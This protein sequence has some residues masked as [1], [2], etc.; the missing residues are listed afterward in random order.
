MLASSRGQQADS[1]DPK[2]QQV[3]DQFVKVLQQY[4][5]A[6]GTILNADPTLMNDQYLARYPAVTAF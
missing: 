6:L 5:P 2:A 1:P 3:R 4:P